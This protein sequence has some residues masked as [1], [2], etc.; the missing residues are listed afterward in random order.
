MLEHCEPLQY[1]KTPKL[2]PSN[3]AIGMP[4]TTGVEITEITSRTKEAK[5]SIVKGVAGFS[6]TAT[7]ASCVCL[8]LLTA[9]SARK[10]VGSRK[11][12]PEVDRACR[13]E[14]NH[15]D[16]MLG[17]IDKERLRTMVARAKSGFCRNSERFKVLSK[18]Y[19]VD[20]LPCSCG[21][22]RIALTF[23]DGGGPF[24]DQT[25]SHHPIG[26][27]CSGISPKL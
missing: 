5:S 26:D 6:I 22:A 7:S 9:W 17:N 2:T 10:E 4:F 8:R 12:D 1:P 20:Q 13:P 3:V 11:S 21:P 18:R 19:P 15:G 23:L 24:V 14:G 25:R 16:Q 27:Y